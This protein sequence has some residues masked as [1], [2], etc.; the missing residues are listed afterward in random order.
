MT[1]PTHEAA[2]DDVRDSFSW[3]RET[4]VDL[5]PEALDSVPAPGANSITVLI[6]HALP[7]TRFWM[8][9]GSGMSPS[10]RSY[11]LNER[12]GQFERKGESSRYHLDSLTS[13]NADIEVALREGSEEHLA[14]LFGMDDEPDEIPITGAHCL[15]HGVSHLREHAGQAALTRQLWLARD[16]S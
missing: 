1:T 12:A 5:P 14:A 8:R 15:M 10:N 4:V 3:L 2:L 9:A 6:C 16:P 7:S 11:V 13:F